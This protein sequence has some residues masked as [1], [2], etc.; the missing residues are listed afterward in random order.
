GGERVAC[1]RRVERRE[2]PAATA[3]VATRRSTF[4][5]GK[6]RFGAAIDCSYARAGIFGGRI[7]TQA[8]RRIGGDRD[9]EHACRPPTAPAAG[10]RTTMVAVPPQFRWWYCR[11]KLAAMARPESGRSRGYANGPY[12]AHAD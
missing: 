12:P 9:G 7:A 4:A 6:S 11:A 1:G 5:A 2:Q 10:T 8:A 3:G